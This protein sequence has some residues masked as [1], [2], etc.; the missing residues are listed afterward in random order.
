MDQLFCCH[1]QSYESLKDTGQELVI[2]ALSKVSISKYHKE[3]SVVSWSLG[4]VSGMPLPTPKFNFH[5]HILKVLEPW[6]A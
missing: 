2:L 4:Y 6:H 1:M 5:T 3:K